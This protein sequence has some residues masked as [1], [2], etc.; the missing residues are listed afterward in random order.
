[1]TA[2][3]ANLPDLNVRNSME[4]RQS[5]PTIRHRHSDQ[6]K[7]L[8]DPK[9]LKEVDVSSDNVTNNHNKSRTRQ[10]QQGF[11]MM[12]ST[13][14]LDCKQVQMQ[15]QLQRRR[16][17]RIESAIEHLSKNRRNSSQTQSL[18]FDSEPTYYRFQV[19][20]QFL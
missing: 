16:P 8:M 10:K 19:L 9:N 14:S 5:F 3:V 12:G 11:H 13:T 2:L 6:P 1:M 4:L 18:D 20:Y 15:N 17:P 7:R